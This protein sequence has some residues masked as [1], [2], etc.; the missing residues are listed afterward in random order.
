[1]RC[2]EL[3]AERDTGAPGGFGACHSLAGC[4]ANRG[5]G[6]DGGLRLLLLDLGEGCEVEER[7]GLVQDD[8]DEE[9]EGYPEPKAAYCV[10][11][12]FCIVSSWAYKLWTI[13]TPMLKGVLRTKL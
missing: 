11:V 3:V 13:R 12:R 1:V 5:R 2:S 9:C 10:L 7:V 6:M 4:E 8:E